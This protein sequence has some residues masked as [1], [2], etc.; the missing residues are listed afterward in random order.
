MAW[1]TPKIDWVAAD[2]VRAAD[3]N[4]I[5]G[6]ILALSKQSA[7]TDIILYVATTGN[8]NAGDGSSG[9]PY[10]TLSKAI[11]VM[12]KQLNGASCAI[13]VAAGTYREDV[14]IAGFTAPIELTGNGT[15]ILNSLI[16]EGCVVSTSG[17]LD[18][19]T[20]GSLIVRSNGTLVAYGDITARGGI[21]VRDCGNATCSILHAYGTYAV[22]VYN[23]SRLHASN[24]SGSGTTYG[25][26]VISGG[27]LSYDFNGVNGTVRTASGGRIYAGAQTAGVSP[28]L[29]SETV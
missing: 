27:I 20:T 26:Y 9:N 18:I 23:A 5:E 29:P 21:T 7:N 17:L 8:D 14:V 28:G 4:R 19:E 11:S 3:M 13:E 6:N 24:M 10:A 15:V 25:L 1:E 2:G 16:I 22:S 12:P